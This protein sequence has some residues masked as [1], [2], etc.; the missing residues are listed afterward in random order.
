MD[1]MVHGK[2]RRPEAFCAPENSRNAPQRAAGGQSVRAGGE[3]F[4]KGGFIHIGGM[5]RASQRLEEAIDVLREAV[6]ELDQ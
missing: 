2:V 4:E 3:Q 1:R 5:E 6:V